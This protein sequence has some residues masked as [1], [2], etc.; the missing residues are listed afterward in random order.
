MK[1]MEL[2]KGNND[3]KNIEKI[4]NINILIEKNKK[5]EIIIQK[6]EKKMKKQINKSNF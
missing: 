2:K 4:E 5:S 1:D 6:Y 3:I